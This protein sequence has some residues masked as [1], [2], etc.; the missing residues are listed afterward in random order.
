MVKKKNVSRTIVWMICLSLFS[1]KTHCILICG[2]FKYKSRL[3]LT[4]DWFKLNMHH[5]SMAQILYLNQ[6]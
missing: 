4:T 2:F 1:I 3:F 5:N 6:K